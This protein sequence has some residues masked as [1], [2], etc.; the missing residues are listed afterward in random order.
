MKDYKHSF[1][2]LPAS[3]VK[4]LQSLPVLHA[5]KIIEL[6]LAKIALVV[7][8]S[9]R[10]LGSITDGDIRRA[11]LN[12]AT[13]ES[14]VRDVM[15]KSPTT[16]PVSSTKK[17]VIDLMVESHIKQIPLVSNDGKLVG[18]AVYDMLTGFEHTARSNAVVIMAGGKGKRLLPIT[19]DIPKPMIEVG[20][21]P[22]LEQILQQF[23][24]QGFSNFY[25]AVNYLGHV[26]ED[27]FGDGSKFNCHI[28]YVYEPEFLGTAGALSL[29]KS[30]M[31]EAFI[32]MNGDIITSVDFCDILDY[33][34]ASKSIA[35][36]CARQHLTSVPYG[37]IKLKEGKIETIVEK[38]VYEDLISAGIYVF[39]P[40]MLDFIPEK[41]AIDMPDVLLSLVKNNQKVDV[42]SMR[43]DWVDVGRHDDLEQVRS[44][45]K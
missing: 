26:I 9:G 29:I 35:T 31:K 8:D 21:K 22:M 44:G 30:E 1:P 5:I 41:T 24:K 42:Y 37:V 40:Q 27:Y 12:G 39:N 16:M 3:E 4:I 25:L 23:I 7:D 34:N 18:I 13:L 17:Q 38:P 32:V 33:H 45:K 28:K 10:L 14:P 11:F 15:Y 20:G 43:E 36:I 2:I 6:S 19:S